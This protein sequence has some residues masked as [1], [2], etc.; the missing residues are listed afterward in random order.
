MSISAVSERWQTKRERFCPHCKMLQLELEFVPTDHVWFKFIFLMESSKRLLYTPAHRR[1]RCR[2]YVYLTRFGNH[3]LRFL[4]PPKPDTGGVDVHTEKCQ[5]FASSSHGGRHA[6]RAT[7]PRA[8][9]NWEDGTTTVGLPGSQ[10]SRAKASRGN[11][12]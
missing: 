3:P 7:V 10:T 5:A 6:S 9:T 1:H 2:N 12:S 11:G 8:D 4:K